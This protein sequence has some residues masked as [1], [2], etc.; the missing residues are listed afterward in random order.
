MKCLGSSD[1]Y[2]FSLCKSI[3]SQRVPQT[4]IFQS[5]H[6]GEHQDAIVVDF[7][8]QVEN[9][10]SIVSKTHYVHRSFVVLYVHNVIGSRSKSYDFYIGTTHIIVVG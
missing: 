1:W 3:L 9:V 10:R 6:D 5:Q 2:L 8:L 7:V 4:Y